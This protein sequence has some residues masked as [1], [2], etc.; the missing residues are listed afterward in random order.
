MHKSY[1]IDPVDRCNPPR[2]LAECSNTLDCG[3]GRC[4]GGVL[5]FAW[6]VGKNFPAIAKDVSITI[7]NSDGH[8]PA[9]MQLQGRKG[10]SDG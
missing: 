6:F 10:A 1:G 7:S 4:A 8:P 9:V 5:S 3:H 2:F